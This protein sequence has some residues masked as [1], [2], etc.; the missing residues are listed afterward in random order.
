MQYR[1]VAIAG[2][3]RL[4]QGMVQA[5]D[6]RR[7]EEMLAGERLR[8][9]SVERV[10]TWAPMQALGAATA[11]VT[12]KEV[13]MFSRTLATMLGSGTPLLTA[14]QLLRQE[15][16]NPA[17]QKVLDGLMADLR[18]GSSLHHAMAKAPKA[19]P[20][21]YLRLVEA[22]ERSGTLETVLRHL[23]AYLEREIALAQQA[24]KAL[25][26][27]AIVV[28]VGLV[29]AGVLV[30]FVLP[31]FIGLLADFQAKLPLP[32]RIL[33]TG[34]RALQAW[35]VPGLVAL[36]ALGVGMVWYVRKPEGRLKVD[37][38]LLKLPGIGRAALL[39]N[40]ARFSRTLSLLLG[41]GLPVSEG[42]LLA[43]DAA[44]NRVFRK[45]I[46]AVRTQVMEGASLTQGMRG[47]PFLPGL[48][49][50]MVKIGEE[51]GTLE[52]NLATMADMYERE[53]E[54]RLTTMTSLLEP[55]MTLAIGGGVAFI[56]LSMLL[57]MLSV[58]KS[59]QGA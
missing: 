32:T 28:A 30:T 25:T 50:Q 2:D 56:A 24:K 23:A 51:S 17:F 54:E 8:V 36:L 39:W 5:S 20:S 16:R 9:L 21:V 58:L 59:V 53:V 47:V 29:V 1:Y 10:F 12:K 43:R 4:V 44:S 26:Y 33:M 35:K 57:P 49:V 42:L 34:S 48:F 14:I 22:G 55:A 27:P 38:W 41:A 13:A 11:V 40:L 15:T 45:G 18:T 37:G 7:A 52:G 3:E 46:T 19:F 6:A 31:T